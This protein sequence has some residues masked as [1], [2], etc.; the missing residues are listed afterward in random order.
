MDTSLQVGERPAEPAK[1]SAAGWAV[2]CAFHGIYPVRDM[3]DFQLSSKRTCGQ[4]RRNHIS[5]M[6]VIQDQHLRT[7]VLGKLLPC[8]IRLE[9]DNQLEAAWRLKQ[10]F[11]IAVWSP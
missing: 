9:H 7:A 5:E 2:L 4:S 11:D 1:T 10:P 6:R 3:S 8:T